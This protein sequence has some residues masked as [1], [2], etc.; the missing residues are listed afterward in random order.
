M[1][2][3]Y[4]KYRNRKYIM[5]KRYNMNNAN[6]MFSLNQDV[7]LL[8]KKSARISIVIGSNCVIVNVY[9]KTNTSKVYE[10]CE[11]FGFERI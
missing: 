5:E 6:Q 3:E 7:M 9:C 8:T 10:T 11:K 2:N 4:D 1:R